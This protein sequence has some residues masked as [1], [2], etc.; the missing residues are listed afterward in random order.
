MRTQAQLKYKLL[1]RSPTG[2]KQSL[3]VIHSVK[4]RLAEYDYQFDYHPDTTDA[5]LA[6]DMRVLCQRQDECDAKQEEHAPLVKQTLSAAGYTAYVGS[7]AAHIEKPNEC[8]LHLAFWVQER[9]QWVYHRWEA[10]TPS[11]LPTS[12]QV[13]DFIVAHLTEMA[14]D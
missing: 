5:E 12:A 11:Q 1:K 9:H 7:I 2:K 6:R 13:T 8:F 10:G 14:D 3:K 4:S